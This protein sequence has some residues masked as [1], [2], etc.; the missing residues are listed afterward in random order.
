MRR[1]ALVFLIAFSAGILIAYFASIAITCVAVALI[2][3]SVAYLFASILK[4]NENILNL[5]CAVLIT[6]SGLFW[7]LIYTNL[8]PG[9]HI[10]NYQNL[11]RGK[12]NFVFVKV[13]NEPK[14][15]ISQTLIE[16]EAESI[17]VNTSKS[18]TITGKLLLR[19]GYPNNEFKYGDRLKLVNPVLLIPGLP[20]NPMEFNYREYLARNKIYVTATTPDIEF[21]D[22][23]GGNS[24]MKVAFKMK[25]FIRR[26][27]DDNLTLNQASLLKGLTIGERGIIPEDVQ[28]HFRNTGTIHI[29]AMSGQQISLIAV[30]IF[31]TLTLF[32]V[33][34]IIKQIITAM[35]VIFYAFI[36]GLDP[37]IFRA[38][39]M[40]ILGMLALTAER[41]TDI[42]NV[43]AF[44]ALIILFL[45]PQ[46]LLDAS[47]QLS[48]ICMISLGYLAPVLLNHEIFK[49]RII[50][51]I[52]IIPIFSLAAQIGIAPIIAYYFYRISIVSI[53]A[54][55]IIIPFSGI[56]V[57]LAFLMCIFSLSP[58][59]SLF[60]GAAWLGVTIMLKS[61]EMFN[62]IPNAYI[63]LRKPE[64][65][66]VC[67]CYI[68]IFSMVRITAYQN[69]KKVFIYSLLIGLNI[70]VWTNV[71]RVSK[72]KLQLVCF[73]KNNSTVVIQKN[74]CK[75]LIKRTSL[76]NNK[77]TAGNFDNDIIEAYLRSKGI[78]EIEQ[79]K[80]LSSNDRFVLKYG[81]YS[82]L[83]PENP[84]LFSSKKDNNLIILSMI[85]RK[86]TVVVGSSGAVFIETDG[87]RLTR[88]AING[89]EQLKHR[90]L[91]YFGMALI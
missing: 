27:I 65:V 87:N 78:K 42:L 64:I 7:S 24:F 17:V 86:D 71:Y 29:L 5:I 22:N 41:D 54:N 37:P 72:N 1:P 80:T 83:F 69:A 91:R 77:N 30:I 60:S 21:I 35:L 76:M 85:A 67:F 40:S 39:I 28:E 4:T 32:R 59:V 43:L 26:T 31:L 66:F 58:L 36:V 45:N 74:K 13:I 9:N 11:F 70:L 82:F 19:I 18:I 48:F 49:K 68:I 6:I 14:V 81:E 79:I 73:A 63:W 46:S 10:L 34:L 51:Y 44:S 12:N 16:C 90:L 3:M 88:H 2:V 75:M 50:K 15:K 62:A 25:N 33:P 57:A 61:A 52:L 8:R 23:S 38:A 89:P 55:L 56:C 47:F 20:L 84:N 53:I